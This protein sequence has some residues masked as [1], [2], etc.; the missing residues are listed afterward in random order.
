MSTVMAISAVCVTS[1]YAALNSYAHNWWM[2]FG[3]VIGPILILLWTVI[4]SSISPGWIWTY[5]YG[6]CERTSPCPVRCCE[7]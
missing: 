6:A 7:R 2:F 1:A 3:Y 4:Y 5:V